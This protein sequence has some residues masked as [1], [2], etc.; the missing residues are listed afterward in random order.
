MSNI[1]FIK[2]ATS[3]SAGF[4]AAPLSWSN[5]NLQMLFFCGGRKPRDPGENPSEQGQ[6]QTQPTYGIG[7]ESNPGH[8]GGRRAFLPLHHPCFPN[9]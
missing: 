7:P 5:W 1:S 8:I 4:H 2:E 9:I 6:Q 3:A